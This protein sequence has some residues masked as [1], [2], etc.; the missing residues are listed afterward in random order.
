[1]VEAAGKT[2]VWIPNVL[3]EVHVDTASSNGHRG[4]CGHDLS[5]IGLKDPHGFQRLVWAMKREQQQGMASVNM[6][7]GEDSVASLNATTNS[8]TQMMTVLQD[9]REEL[10]QLRGQHLWHQPSAPSEE[11]P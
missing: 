11:G 4:K 6:R 7:R 2:L 5:L 9:I 1:M 3:H 8:D 10:R